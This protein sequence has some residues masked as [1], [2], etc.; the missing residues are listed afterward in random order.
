VRAHVWLRHDA[1]QHALCIHNKRATL[2]LYQVAQVPEWL[3][4]SDTEN[5][6]LHRISDMQSL[7]RIGEIVARR[8]T[9]PWQRK[10]CS[11]YWR[12]TLQRHRSLRS[13]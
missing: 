12:R 13:F 11:L 9:T 4:F 3:R 5:L 2:F 1:N 6:P 7:H 10:A 8:A